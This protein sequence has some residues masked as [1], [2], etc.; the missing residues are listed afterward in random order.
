M[1][2]AAKLLILVGA[3][4]KEAEIGLK[5][6]DASLKGMGGAAN[7]A[8]GVFAGQ[9]MVGAVNGVRNLAAQGLSAYTSYERLGM[10]LE[11]LAAREILSAGGARSM[12]EALK[13]A[14]PRAGALLKWVE[15]LA[16]KSPFT[17][18]G[19]ASA[20]RRV[21]AYVFAE[22]EAQ[23]LT[24]AM[25]DF[26]AGSGGSTEQ[27]NRIALA[28]GQVRAAGK[29]TGMEMRQLTEAGLPVTE[30]LAKA[31][32]VTTSELV[33]LREKGLIPADKAI[34][35]IVS[36]IENDFGG[37]AARQTET[38]AG[39][40]SSMEDIKDIGLREFFAG[41]FESIRP[42]LVEFNDLMQEPETR[43]A[44]QE[45]GVEFGETVGTIAETARDA[46][47]WVNG[48]D[49]STKN[50]ALSLAG[51]AIA[52]PTAL[53]FVSNVGTTA[54]T[55]AQG[56]LA[57]TKGVGLVT[58]GMTAGMGAA[59]S[60]RYAFGYQA[61]AAGSL[62]LAVLALAG[63]Y[64]Q[65]RNVVNQVEEGTEA[66][67]STWAGQISG[68]ENATAAIKAYADGNTVLTN[69]MKGTSFVTQA[70]IDEDHM[71]VEA[72]IALEQKLR[73]TAG[74]YDEY[75]AAITG[76][77][78]EI[79]VYDQYV[80]V[81]SKAEFAELR[82]V[83]A[84]KAGAGSLQRYNQT[85]KATVSI[86]QEAGAT[87]KD[88]EEAL[89]LVSQSLN[90]YGLAGTDTQAVIDELA[91]SMGL[92]DQ[93]QA[94]TTSDMQLATQ[95]Y[96]AGIIP[97]SQ[98]AE[99]T[100]QA[101]DG[102]FGLT[103]AQ[104]EN[105]Q[106]TLDNAAAQAELAPKLAD[107]AVA[108]WDLAAGLKD[109]SNAEVANT[110]I[111]QLKEALDTGKISPEQYSQAV[112]Q[113]QEA[114]GLSDEKS[115]A[116]AEGIGLVTEAFGNGLIP[117][118]NID[119]ALAFIAKD[120]ADG[121]LNLGD[122][123]TK[124]GNMPSQIT[125]GVEATTAFLLNLQKLYDWIKAN[126]LSVTVDV[127]YPTL[128]GASGTGSTSDYLPS[129]DYSGTATPPG[130]ARGGPVSASS[131]YVVGERGPELFVPNRAGTIVPG[132]QYG[133]TTLSISSPMQVV[134]TDAGASAE[135]IA[136]QIGQAVEQSGQVLLREARAR[137]MM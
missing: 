118:Q 12:A 62:G 27:M 23:R 45:L 66:V 8:F 68:A 101:A 42:Y 47:V 81:L 53:K 104:R 130:R 84:Y 16:I 89:K 76:A 93:A 43:A 6:L 5:S 55:A 39:L 73:Q 90:E 18:D 123:L 79:K 86:E 65:Y 119:E 44:I 46:I 121:A 3:E 109:A 129:E 29:L 97:I 10:S 59:D 133:N 108:A 41:T 115:R 49:E 75:R 134:I 38:F 32:G 24:Q 74:S 96:V 107:A 52:G 105:W 2:I 100:K 63:V 72:L 87:L 22:E 85:Q 135:D 56:V 20:F 117:A 21:Q 33:E 120:S 50:W 110:A 111:A 99:Y 19:I 112:L 1:T 54:T 78:T 25:V 17:Q 11:S 7:T 67:N 91:L 31:F 48:L 40:M 94:A 69:T 80:D 128:P 4:T 106:T 103:E 14:E 57:L 34:Q 95:A 60:L 137:G 64:M 136:Y 26:S 125:P 9:M 132:G 92:L 51:I 35:A 88:K 28:L 98:L 70:L 82:M 126:P 37:A 113:I 15:Q 71:R 13:L 83:E 77:E 116:L 61:A 36:T 102:T 114:Y 131:P 58:E 127:N 122:L 124:F 30:I